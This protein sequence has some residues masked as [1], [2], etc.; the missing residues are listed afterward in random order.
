MCRQLYLLFAAAAYACTAEAMLPIVDLGYELHQATSLSNSLYNFSNIRY[1]APPVGD[2]RF[3]ASIP[4]QTD[5]SLVQTGS[6]GRI[7]P[8]AYPVWEEDIAL[9]WVSSVL[10]GTTFTGSTNI[11]SYPLDS[12]PVDP[13]TTEDCLF[14]DV[15]V[16]KDVFEKQGKASVLVWIY[17][18]GYVSGDKANENAKGLVERSLQ[19]GQDGIV[20]VAINYRLGAF[21]WLAGPSLER[22]GTANAGLLDQRLA[23]EWVQKYIHVFGGDPDKVTVMGESAGAGSILF[24]ITAY[25]G[26]SGPA[27]FQ[28]AILQ[29]PAWHPIVY[30]DQQEEAFRNFL[31]ILGVKTLD[32]ARK[33]SSERL[34][35]ANAYQVGQS[36]YGA[37]TYGPVADGKIAPALP[38]QLLL[39]NQF[40]NSNNLKL[41]VAHNYDEGLIFTSP[42]SRAND[43]FPTLIS[44]AF[45]QIKADVAKYIT[46]VLYPPVYNGSYGYTTSVGRASLAI[47]D[48]AIQ[49]NTDY[50]NR[51]FGN[52]TYAYM[53]SVPPGIHAQDTYYTFYNNGQGASPF[54]A[55]NVTIALA[56]QDYITS[57]VQTGNPTSSYGPALVK[58]GNRQRLVDLTSDGVSVIADPTAN[59]RCRWWQG[60]PYL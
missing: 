14:L 7:C 21:G 23:L 5:R 12:T 60:A 56:L 9:Q 13:R 34:I 32:E 26:A 38:G 8:A 39:A 57:F 16:P 43:S 10:L 27:P 3:R 31:D 35:A 4:P 17:G 46:Q 11:S 22:E 55:T 52:S 58:D 2:L 36:S 45:P 19:N 42:D 30:K 15:V 53:F 28:Q 50:L 20:Y 18:G 54:G 47:S 24:Q 6:I 37:F 49:C 33:L 29:S 51:A 40:D 48:F 1:A 25:G 59:E 41:I 44:A